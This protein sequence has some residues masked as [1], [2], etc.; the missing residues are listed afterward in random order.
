LF[1]TAIF[2]DFTHFASLPAIA[3]LGAPTHPSVAIPAVNSSDLTN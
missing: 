2:V 1:C 3:G